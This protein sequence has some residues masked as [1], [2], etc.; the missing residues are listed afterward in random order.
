M[1]TVFDGIKYFFKKKDLLSQLIIVNIAV[2]LIVRLTEVLLKLFRMNDWQIASC[3]QFPSSFAELAGK[4]WTS[5][6]YMFLHHDLLHILF[7]MLWLYWFGK[8]FLL[9]FN[10]KQL[11]GTYLL[12][13]IAGALFFLLSF[14]IFPYFRDAVET[15]RLEGA[16]A[17]VMAI[18]FAASFYKKDFRIYLL[19]LGSI[20]IYYVAMASLLLDILDITS[21]NAGGHIAHIGGALFGIAYAYAYQRGTDLTRGL[22]KCMDR[23]ANLFKKK[24]VMKVTFHRRE[25][26]YQYNDRK[27]KENE[28]IDRILDK[29]KKSGYN[30]L[31]K[32]EKKRLFDASK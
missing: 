21:S 27:N 3:L 12:G 26:D 29:I 22:N 25:S 16:S 1:A 24:P 8:I 9:F 31:S 17:A 32:E 13:G 15:G 30:S 28:E 18:V 23:F 6:T 5:V 11:L 10:S 2:F 4:P 20:K 19:F 14:N 7:N